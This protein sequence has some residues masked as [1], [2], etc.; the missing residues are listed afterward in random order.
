MA[1]TITWLG[2]DLVTGKIIAELPELYPNGTLDCRLCAYSSADLRLPL[3]SGSYAAPPLDWQSAIAPNRTLLVCVTNDTP[4]WGAIPKVGAGG[5]ESS[6]NIPAAT[7]ESYLDSRYVGNHN[8]V[9]QD[10]ASVI[11][12]GLAADANVEGI[13]LIVDAPAVGTLLTREYFDYQ[14]KTVY[15]ALRELSGGTDGIEWIIRLG[16][17]D[18]TMTAVSK[19]LMI[20]RRIGIA[21]SVPSAVF[22]VSS[23]SAVVES[24]GESS[25]TYTVTR[26]FSSGRGA[27]HVVAVSSGQGDTRPQSSPARDEA[28]IAAGAPRWE[29]RFTPATSITDTT[30]LDWHAA[31]AL[32]A[33]KDGQQ[34]IKIVSRAD[35]YP[36]L[37]RDWN[38][39]DDIGYNLTGHAHLDGIEGVA[40]AT[41]YRFDPQARTVEPVLLAPGEAI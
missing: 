8:W 21:A 13:N 22:D 18:S 11:A 23:A 29:H 5:T 1:D 27:N 41:A 16:W 4:I 3:A 38:V 36:M 6:Y 12:T 35:A 10:I 25:T 37:G 2:C 20:R 24:E 33:M 28:Q 14:D 15:S 9:N 40:R 26:D 32:A 17:T 19:T 34:T 39:G 31:G 7:V 30:Q